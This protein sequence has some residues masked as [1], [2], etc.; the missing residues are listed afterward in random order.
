LST[1][2]TSKST[3]RLLSV[4]LRGKPGF[5]LAVV[6]RRFDLHPHYE[7]KDANRREQEA[8]MFE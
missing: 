1:T 8:V 5:A 6:A 4:G 3:G 2:A 7:L